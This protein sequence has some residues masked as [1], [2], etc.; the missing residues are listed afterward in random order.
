MQSWET[1]DGWSGEEVADVALVRLCAELSRRKLL[2]VFLSVCSIE[3]EASGSS[4]SCGVEEG[5]RRSRGRMSFLCC[6]EIFEDE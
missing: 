1:A 2:V 3:N 5:K 4:K 6:S